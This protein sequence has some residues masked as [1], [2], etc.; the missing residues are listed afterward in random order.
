MAQK[1]ALHT[2]FFDLDGTLIDT[3][4]AAAK[5]IRDTFDEWQIPVSQSDA[6]RVTGVTWETAFRFLYSRYHPPVPTDEATHLILARY[7][8]A[9]REHLPEVPGARDAV[10][11]LA[12]YTRLAVVSGSHHHTIEWALKQI[13]IFEHFELVLG[14]EDYPQSKPAPDGYLKGLTLLNAAPATS[15]VFEDS[16]AGITSAKAAGIQVV[17]LR[18]TNYLNQDQSKAD[19]FIHDLRDVSEAWI[20]GLFEVSERLA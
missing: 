16:F 19:W 15:I 13:G 14:A 6:D 20:H 2:V 9:L 1:K 18:A 17:A 5:V 7:H 8:A 11:L 3:E 12:K 4:Q 10:R